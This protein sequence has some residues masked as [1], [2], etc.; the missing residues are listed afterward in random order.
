MD[1]YDRKAE[2]LLMCGAAALTTLIIFAIIK[3]A[4][5]VA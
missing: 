3:I 5:A 1:N 2:F 4:G